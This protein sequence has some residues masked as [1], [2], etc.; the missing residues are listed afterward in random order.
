[1]AAARARGYAEGGTVK[2]G[3]GVVG[4]KG[5]ERFHLGPQGLT[6]F[7][8]EMSKAMGPMTAMAGYAGGAG[9]D[10]TKAEKFAAAVAGPGGWTCAGPRRTPDR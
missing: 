1:M 10:N 6:I 3:W 8:H 4:E 7:P 5:W 2:S 9:I